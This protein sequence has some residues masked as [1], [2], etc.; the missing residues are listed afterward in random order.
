M[1]TSKKSVLWYMFWALCVLIKGILFLYLK[2][3][4]SYLK[5]EKC[6]IALIKEG[7]N[8]NWDMQV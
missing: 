3:I 4:E 7:V 1:V 8:Y 2:A 5:G 6:E